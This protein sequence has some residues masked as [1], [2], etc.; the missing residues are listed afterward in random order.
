MVD[1]GSCGS[2]TNHS[3][4]EALRAVR[5]S[6]LDCLAVYGIDYDDM[7]F[8]CYHRRNKGMGGNIERGV[9]IYGKIGTCYLCFTY[10]P[11]FTVNLVL[12]EVRETESER[13]VIG[14]SYIFIS[15]L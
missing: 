13:S 11:V 5:E 15:F 9:V 12:S 1:F 2:V 3:S 14:R 4:L 10:T 6:S 7:S 8:V